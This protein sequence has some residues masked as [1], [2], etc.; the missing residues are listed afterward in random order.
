MNGVGRYIARC[1]LSSE[2]FRS[3]F[4]WI[5]QD[6][7]E[8]H[9]LEDIGIVLIS[10]MC[11]QYQIRATYALSAIIPRGRSNRSLLLH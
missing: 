6:F 4:A 9:V 2:T 10:F 1:F 11:Q 3:F 5:T 7:D 8:E